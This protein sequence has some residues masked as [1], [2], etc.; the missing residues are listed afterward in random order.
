MGVLV[1]GVVALV[2]L[3]SELSMSKIFYGSTGELLKERESTS[4]KEEA[5]GE[6]A[7]E[8]KPMVTSGQS[9]ASTEL[10]EADVTSNEAPAILPGT[11]DCSFFDRGA[12]GT[13]W[14]GDKKICARCR[15]SMPQKSK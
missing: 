5:T 10:R 11:C 6:A 4:G 13:M 12:L 7:T 9:Q 8:E 14:V 1:G 2:V 3:V 15:K